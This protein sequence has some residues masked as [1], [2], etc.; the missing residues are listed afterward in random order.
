MGRSLTMATT[1]LNFVNNWFAPKAN[2][3]GVDFGTDSLRL[4]QVKFTGGDYQLTAAASADVPAHVRNDPAARLT[5]FVDTTRDLLAQG[6]FQGRQTILALPSAQMHLLHLRLPKMDDAALRKA[7]AWEIRG[8]IALDP[9]A[10]LIRHIGAGEIYADN[11]P[12][13]EVIVLAAARESVNQYL[14]AAAKAR[15]DVIGMNVEPK[16]LIEC[17]AHIFRRRSDEGL[18]NLF[19]DIGCGATRAIIARGGDV[20]FARS[21]NIGGEHFNRAVAGAMNMSVADAKALRLKLCAAQLTATPAAMPAPVAKTSDSDNSFA[22]LGLNAA[23][24]P[25]PTVE[26]RA[27]ADPTVDQLPVAPLAAEQ[28]RQIQAVQDAC[29]EPLGRLID[30]LDLCRRYYESAFPN[31]CVDRLLFV[32]G[33]ARQRLLCQSIARQMQ[34]A[35]QVGD[36]LCRMGKTCQIGLESGIDRCQPQPGWAVA[37]GLSMGPANVAAEVKS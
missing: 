23:A 34:L 37:I 22:L 16:A 13:L 36:P 1:M 4:A 9:A 19:V 31:R 32:G 25:K 11:D 7:L 15:L 6:H 17:F 29:G 18:T 28:Q 14:A 20:L 3:I 33:E 30:E 12:K 8:K 5:F 26:R 2:P 27:A 21:I 24:D 10:A 35:A